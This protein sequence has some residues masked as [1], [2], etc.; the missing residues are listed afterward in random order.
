MRRVMTKEIRQ[1]AKKRI[2]NPNQTDEQKTLSL[3][4]LLIAI[5][6]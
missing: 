2:K 3:T 4:N 1:R 5:S 6:E